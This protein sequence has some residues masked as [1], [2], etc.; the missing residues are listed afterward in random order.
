MYTSFGLSP[1]ITHVNQ[2]HRNS[3]DVQE[4]VSSSGLSSLK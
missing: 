4:V 3:G 2:I 1:G